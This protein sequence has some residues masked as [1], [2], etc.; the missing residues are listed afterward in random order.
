MGSGRR[1]KPKGGVDTVHSGPDQGS[2]SD[3][4][5]PET[6]S[7]RLIN[8]RE[9]VHRETYVGAPVTIPPQHR[10]LV[11]L[12]DSGILGDIPAQHLHSVES[13]GYQSGEVVEL[14]K[15]P[16]TAVVRLRRL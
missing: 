6:L 7:V 13:L 16:L 1:R 4:A 8:V 9:V 14:A 12:V 10:P 3:P 11:A 15:E 5:A 2:M